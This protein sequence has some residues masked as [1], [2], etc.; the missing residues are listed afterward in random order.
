VC[1]GAI[2]AARIPTLVFG[3]RDPKAGAAGS[4]YNLCADPRLNHEV[5]VV[6]GVRAAEAGEQLRAFFAARR[7]RYP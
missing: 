7:D 4:L 1:A 2:V 5:E 3:A 6:A